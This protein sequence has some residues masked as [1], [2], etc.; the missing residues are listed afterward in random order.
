MALAD[1]VV[2]LALDA[3]TWEKT[4]AVSGAAVL[5]NQVPLEVNDMAL[6]E[7]AETTIRSCFGRSSQTVAK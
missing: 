5:V 7:V 6:P 4:V 1:G 2:A 3:S